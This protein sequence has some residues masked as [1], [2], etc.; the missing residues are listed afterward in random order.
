MRVSPTWNV[1]AAPVLYH[2][3]KLVY[4]HSLNPYDRNSGSRGS[5]PF[6]IPAKKKWI[7]RKSKVPSKEQN[8]AYIRHVTFGDHAEGQCGEAMRT[9]HQSSI[10]SLSL[11]SVRLEHGSGLVSHFIDFQRG[12]LNCAAGSKVKAPRVILFGTTPVFSRS[13][14]PTTET[15]CVFDFTKELG[16]PPSSPSS[17][18]SATIPSLKCLQNTSTRSIYI[19]KPDRPLG[20]FYDKLH[21]SVDGT[22][23]FLYTHWIK[24]LALVATDAWKSPTT[25]EVLIVEVESVNRALRTGATEEDLSR[26]MDPVAEVQQHVA[27]QRPKDLKEEKPFELKFVTMQEYLRDHDWTGVFTEQ[28]IQGWR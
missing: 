26:L 13:P 19:F 4:P 17:L 6:N 25:K 1:I 16:P 2:T 14:I 27:R 20:A 15:I 5:N 7:T 9:L 10:R 22:P 8:L 3:V 23:A 12:W 11:E 24:F 28:E 21:V 18:T